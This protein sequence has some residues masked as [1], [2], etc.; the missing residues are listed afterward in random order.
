MHF[1]IFGLFIEEGPNEGEEAEKYHLYAQDQDSGQKYHFVLFEKTE[2][3]PTYWEVDTYGVFQH[4][5]IDRFPSFQYIPI[6]TVNNQVTLEFDDQ[7][8]DCDLFSYSYDGWDLIDVHD[9]D[10]IAYCR[11]EIDEYNFQVVPI[12]IKSARKI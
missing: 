5:V 12:L 7:R 11:A 10:Y 1:I 8:I 6:E 3:S 9:D 4:E 2:E